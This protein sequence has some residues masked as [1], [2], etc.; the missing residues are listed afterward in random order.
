MYVLCVCMC[1]QKNIKNFTNLKRTDQLLLHVITSS[2][3]VVSR[4]QAVNRKKIILTGVK[5]IHQ[6]R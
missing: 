4:Y 3:G 5:N 1:I 2:M 6:Y